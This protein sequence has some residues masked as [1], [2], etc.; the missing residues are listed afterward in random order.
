[1]LNW[2]FKKAHDLTVAILTGFLIGSLNKIW[3]WKKILKPFI[4]HE[5]EPDEEIVP[6]VEQNILPH[7]YPAAAKQFNLEYGGSLPEDHF[8][9][10][11]ITLAVLGFALIIVL[12]R[13]GT[14]RK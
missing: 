6:L 1:M 12:D 4:K 5:G 9:W 2:L 14:A 7:D 8:L 10:I 13:F 3:P 11:S